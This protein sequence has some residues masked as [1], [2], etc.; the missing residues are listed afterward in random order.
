VEDLLDSIYYYAPAGRLVPGCAEEAHTTLARYDHAMIDPTSLHD[1]LLTWFDSNQADLPWRRNRTPYM[2]WLSEIMLQQTQVAT[3]IPYYERFLARF[4]SVEALAAASLDE[5]LKLWEGLGYYSRARNLHRAAQVVAGDWS[6]EFP[7]SVEDLM[8]LPGV[9]RYTAGAIASLALGLDAPVLDGNVIR[10]LTRLFDLTDDVTQ[11][12]ARRAL[13]ALAE[14]VLPTGRAGPWN[15]GLMELGRL[16]CTPRSPR[17]A[18]CPLAEYC[19]AW[20]RGTQEERPVR[21]PRKKTPHFDVTAGVIWGAEGCLLIA[22]RPLDGMLGGL[23]EFPGG[24]REPG[25]TLPECLRREIREELG[26]EIDVGGQIA[27]I[28]H[29]YTH[30]RITLYAFECQHVSGEP[31]AIECADWAWVALGD[32]DSYAFAVTD[33]QIIAVLREGGGQLGMDLG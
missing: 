19:L 29:A 3:V 10:V 12:A 27:T 13:W 33:Q 8:K 22:Q 11:S 20:A 15:E 14:E 21:S 32:L 26:I 31:G 5:V 28:K 1:A 30:F 16:I 17:C 18:I 7:A 2:V 23:W 24:K 6:G 4:P 9:G 25:E